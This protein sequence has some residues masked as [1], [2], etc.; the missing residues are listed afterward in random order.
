M[1]KLYGPI[2]F[3][4]VGG[5]LAFLP[6]L[7]ILRNYQFQ[8][9]SDKVIAKISSS[10]RTTGSSSTRYVSYEFTV[11][12]SSFTGTTSGYGGAKGETIL[13]EYVTSD[14]SINRVSGAGKRNKKWLWP[15]FG[16]GLFFA[17]VGTHW[18]WTVK[19]REE[20]KKRLPKVGQ[21]TMGKIAKID[22]NKLI[23]YEFE[24]QSGGSFTGYAGPFT[25]TLLD[26]LDVNKSIEVIYD[27]AN[28]GDSILSLELEI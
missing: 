14:P 3:V 2:A 9:G 21:K 7:K 8:G 15:M 1:K 13:V 27:R 25:Q 26:G 16:F 12:G 18:G 23:H 6:G 20:L 11:A 19:K 10:G 22:L 28:P 5:I 17:F 24:D 4:L